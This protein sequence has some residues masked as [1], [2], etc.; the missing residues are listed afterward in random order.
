MRCSGHAILRFPASFSCG[1]GFNAGSEEKER[2]KIEREI[3]R[4]GRNRNTERNMRQ[5]YKT[6]ANTEM[7]RMERGF[8]PP[9]CVQT[10]AQPPH[11]PLGWFQRCIFIFFVQRRLFLRG[12]PQTHCDL[13]RTATWTPTKNRW[14]SEALDSVCVFLKSCVLMRFVRIILCGKEQKTTCVHA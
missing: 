6:K 4:E 14:C 13:R 10:P 12:T 3:E 8:L 5:K 2:R 11:Q 7:K 9:V 1:A